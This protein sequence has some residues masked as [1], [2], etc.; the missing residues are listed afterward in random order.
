[1]SMIAAELEDAWVLDLFA[2]CGG[3]GVEATSRGAAGALLVEL[4]GRAAARL[5][6]VF[7]QEVRVVRG[8]ACRPDRWGVSGCYSVVLVDPPWGQGLDVQALE[9]VTEAGLVAIEATAVI[10]HA[11]GDDPEVGGWQVRRTRRHGDGAVTVLTRKE[12]G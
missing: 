9:A 5:N 3:L 8:D 6:E 2:G 12:D 7:G 10:V 1:M 11:A 4:D